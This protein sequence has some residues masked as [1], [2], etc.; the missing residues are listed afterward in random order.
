MSTDKV[1]KFNVGGKRYEVSG[2]LLEN[3]SDSMLYRSST[4]MWQKNSSEEIFIERDGD[5]FRYCLDYMRDGKVN[6]PFIVSKAALVVDA[7]Y[8]GLKMAGSAV[9]QDIMALPAVEMFKL[10]ETCDYYWACRRLGAFSLLHFLNAE[11]KRSFVLVE[12]STIDAQNNPGLLAKAWNLV[13]RDQQ[14][15]SD[16]FKYLESLGLKSLFFPRGPY[17]PSVSVSFLTDNS[18]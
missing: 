12:K 2:S 5:R 8:D 7:Q 16:F 6:I 1:V 3:H 10:T 9:T 14:H 4:D 18:A 11:S 17:R 13:I 15:R